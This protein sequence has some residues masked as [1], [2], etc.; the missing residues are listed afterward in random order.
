MARR[1][2]SPEANSMGDEQARQIAPT[3]AHH[4]R[5]T[6]AYQS[7]TFAFCRLPEA[8]PPLFCLAFREESVTEMEILFGSLR[9]W[10]FTRLPTNPER[11]KAPGTST[12]SNHARGAR[13]RVCRF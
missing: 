3:E 5:L 6:K 13:L 4:R 1:R 2:P 7:V 9:S 8:L 10:L 11:C 12:P